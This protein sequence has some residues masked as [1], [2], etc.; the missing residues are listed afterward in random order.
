MKVKLFCVYDV[1]A[2]AFMLPQ[3]YH[4]AGVAERAFTQAVNTP[5]TAFN[6][7]PGDYT[8]FEVG[9]FDDAVGLLIAHSTPINV[10][11]G[12]TVLRVSS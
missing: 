11:N 4:T 1:K 8:L 5:D 9:E 7:A 12:I 3:P 10:V 2:N 6:M